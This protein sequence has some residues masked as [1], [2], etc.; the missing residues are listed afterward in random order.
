M[1]QSDRI[2]IH[3]GYALAAGIYSFHQKVSIEKPLL[4]SKA[5]HGMVSAQAFELPSLSPLW[6]PA[7][8]QAFDLNPN[9]KEKPVRL[10][11]G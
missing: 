11:R 8:Y 5:T 9:P 1:S 3:L 7:A 2:T 6:T 4:D 10:D